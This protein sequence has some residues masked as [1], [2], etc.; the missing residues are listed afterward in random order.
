MMKYFFKTNLFFI[1]CFFTF[2]AF[3]KDGLTTVQPGVKLY[4][5]YYPNLSSKFKGTIIFING[6]GVSMGEWKGNKR[7]HSQKF[8]ECA[9][10]VGSLFLYNRSGFYGSPPDYNL[11]AKNPITAKLISEQLSVLL[12]NRHIKPP[13]LI[14]AHSY[15]A[16]AA[17]Y[18]VLKNP[19]L[20]KGLLLIDP[21]PR[22]FYFSNRSTRRV[23]SGIISA[24]NHSAIYIY[25]KYKPS[26]VESFYLRLGFTKTKNELKRHGEISDKIPVVIISSTQMEY[27]SKAKLIKGDWFTSQKQWLNQNSNSKIFQVTSSHIIQQD[28]PKIVC[29]EIRYLSNKNLD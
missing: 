5:E 22:N 20:V 15:F 18:Y 24:K 28:Q 3:S 14:V 1:F 17:G 27:D 11:S 25:K 16:L 19:G 21:V 6:S 12:K 10:K 13:Y 9:K 7:F 2:S 4:S 26:N 23:E 29:D 8:F